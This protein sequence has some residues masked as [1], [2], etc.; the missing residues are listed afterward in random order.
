MSYV[1]F[2][3]KLNSMA[4]KPKP[5][6]CSCFDGWVCEDHPNQPWGHEGC[7]AAGEL[8]RNPDC[9][10]DPDSIFLTV[11][12]GVQPGRKKPPIRKTSLN[13]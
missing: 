12:C 6:T 9:D 2:A 4:A 8:Y 13:A 10:K 7:G 5:T 1:R 3:V 11:H